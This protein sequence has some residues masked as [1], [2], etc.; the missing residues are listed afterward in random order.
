MIRNKIVKGLFSAFLSII[1]SANIL[2]ASALESNESVNEAV[3]VV[4]GLG[5]RLNGYILAI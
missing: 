4:T 5:I 3:E 2:S 1:I